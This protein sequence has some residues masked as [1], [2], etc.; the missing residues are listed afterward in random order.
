[1]TLA[2][3]ALMWVVVSFLLMALVLFSVG[4]HYRLACWLDRPD[5]ASWLASCWHLV[6]AQVQP[7]FARGAHKPLSIESKS[8]GQGVYPAVLPILLCLAG[9][10]AARRR[11]TL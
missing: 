1:M 4:G 6:A 3:K 9:A 7:C 5:P 2:M 11:S 8:L 10:D